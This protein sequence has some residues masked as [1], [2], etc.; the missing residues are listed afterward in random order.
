MALR[1]V[2]VL[3]MAGLAPAPF[4]GMI[5]ADFG[6]TVIRVDRPQEHTLDTLARGKRSIA[7][8]LKEK[9]GVEVVRRLCKT[10][11]VVLEPYRPGVME[12]MGLGPAELMQEN[13]RLI[14]ARLTGFGQKGVFSQMAGHDINY[15]SMSG[16]LSMLG[17][18]GEKPTP[19]INLLAD[20]AGGGLMCALGITMALLERAQSGKGQVIDASMVQG[21][22]YIG[23]FLKTSQN[24]GLWTGE[25]GQ[26]FLDTGAPFYDTFVTSDGQHMA[27]GAI[28]GQFYKELI[29]GLEIDPES[30]PP[31]VSLDD[32][33][34]VKDTIAKKFA[35]RTRDEWCKVFDGTDACVTPV[36]SME[37]AA[38]HPHNKALG[39][40]FTDDEGESMPAPAPVLS[41]SAAKPAHGR[42]PMVGEHTEEVLTESG[43]SRREISELS[44]QGAIRTKDMSKL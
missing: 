33:P 23:T 4:C 26:N 7:V 12:K 24:L 17:R 9:S 43:F 29:K 5:L 22:A 40:Y 11:D 31:Q 3:E 34:Q 2:K 36:L 10:A 25:R 44:Q 16:M 27:V 37:E 30:L 6:A 21:A 18:H 13:K 42:Q 38:E 35:S 39:T 19:P 14:Y 15:L 8:N 20:F 1:G 41:R 32:W 28:E